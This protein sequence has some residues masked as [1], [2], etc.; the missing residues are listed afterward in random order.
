MRR[1]ALF[2]LLC[3]T[4][5][6][7]AQERLPIRAE[8]STI[9]EYEGRAGETIRII[10]SVVDADET[11]PDLVLWLV[12]NDRLLAYSDNGSEN[13]QIQMTLPET[14]FYQI[15]L[16]SFNGVSAG[17]ADLIVETIDPFN[18]MQEDNRLSIT[19]PAGEVFRYDFEAEGI[20]TI[21]VKDISG[22]IDPYIRLLD[23]T[24]AVIA[25]NDDHAS[26]DLSLDLLDSRLSLELAAARYTLEIR[27]FLGRAGQL[28]IYID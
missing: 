6:A 21:H 1:I 14:G 19:L 9:H 27:D 23:E 2:C 16:D 7:F 25:E 11:T 22:G 5:S 20:T 4:I 10:A 28:A 8:A 26:P 15:Y 13:P 17:K 12:Y 24:G 3:L 18:I